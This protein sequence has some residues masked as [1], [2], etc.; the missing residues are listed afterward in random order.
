MII[1]AI[2][3]LNTATMSF[4]KNLIWNNKNNAQDI[5]NMSELTHYPE[6]DEVISELIKILSKQSREFW[7]T[8]RD[9]M[10][11]VK[12]EFLTWSI[13]TE[14]YEQ[15]ISKAI[16]DVSY[17]ATELQRAENLMKGLK[18]LWLWDKRIA[19]EFLSEEPIE[20]NIKTIAIP[21][22]KYADWFIRTYL[23]HSYDVMKKTN[24]VPNYIQ[25]LRK[26]FCTIAKRY[27]ASQTKK[28]KLD[29]ATFKESF[30]EIN[31]EL[32]KRWITI[33]ATDNI[34]EEFIKI[35]REKYPLAKNSFNSIFENK[36]FKND[37]IEKIIA[38]LDDFL[39]DYYSE[40]IK[41]T[42][43]FIALWVP[44]EKHW[45]IV[46][47]V[48]L[49]YNTFIKEEYWEDNIIWKF[50]LE[51]LDTFEK[52]HNRKLKNQ[53]KKKENPNK[54]TTLNIVDIPIIDEKIQKWRR[55]K[56]DEEQNDLIKEAISYINCDEAKKKSIEKF[57]TKL[58]I[59]DFPL[60]FTDIKK[61][62]KLDWIPENTIKILTEQLW[63]EYQT[64]KEE[65]KENSIEVTKSETKEEIKEEKTT[66]IIIEDPINYFIER[67]E[68]FNY[69]IPNKNLLKKQ[70]TEF[71]KNSTYETV[72][73]NQLKNPEFWKVLYHRGWHKKARV[74]PIWRTGW[75]LLLIKEWKEI[76]VDSFCNHDDYRD[77]LIDI[78]N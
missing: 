68:S 49:N 53:E 46:N 65:E 8:Y 71:R 5:M 27:A 15:Q 74:L 14:Y 9:F 18:Y 30:S 26:T 41:R 12:T 58:I 44:W 70:I 37:F 59:K 11:K 4:E 57:I 76:T 61:I 28:I 33:P 63:L 67:I 25:I 23:K 20:E 73:T 45:Y 35:C 62:F 39:D 22:T 47:N 3:L 50:F 55:Y 32:E 51:I 21:F 1:I 40:V 16:E 34:Q 13:D 29:E 64:E 42:E 2:P 54:N 75:R 69:I 6:D 56:L 52:D 36:K 77:R 38:S 72:L 7:K 17:D 10:E 66:E 24:K 43:N 48:L 60:R 31:T 78:K 19:R